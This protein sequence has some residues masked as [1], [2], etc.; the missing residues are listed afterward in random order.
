M[1]TTSEN[2]KSAVYYV[3]VFSDR[4]YIGPSVQDFCEHHIL[5]MRCLINFKLR[6]DITIIKTLLIMCYREPKN[7]CDI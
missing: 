3:M 6:Y 1:L 7:I 5:K 4:L 2:L